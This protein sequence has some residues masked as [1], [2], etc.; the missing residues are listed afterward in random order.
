MKHYRQISI[1]TAF[2]KLPIL[3]YLY[4]YPLKLLHMTC[5]QLPTPIQH[6][7]LERG[8]A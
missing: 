1:H 8:E 2:I 6:L 4:N 5:T 3:L 7:A